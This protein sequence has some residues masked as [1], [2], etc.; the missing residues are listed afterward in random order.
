MRIVLQ[1]VRKA[2]VSIEGKLVSSIDRGY[3]LLV[4]FTEGDTPAVAK[5]M[6]DK[7]CKLRVFPDENG[8][9]NQSL[10]DVQGNILCVSQFTLYASVKE[11]NRPSFTSCM[12]ADDARVLYGQFYADLKER[13]PTLQGGVFQADMVV[14]LENDGPFTLILDSKELFAK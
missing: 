7:V 14:S 3:L 10:S 12:K 11:G 9:T 4:G 2:S 13:I 6:C 8:K 1:V 5:K